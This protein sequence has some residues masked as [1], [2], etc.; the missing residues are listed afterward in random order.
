MKE[1]KIAFT[2]NWGQDSQVLYNKYKLI[3]PNRSG[4]WNYLKGV[5]TVDDADVVFM[6]DGVDVRDAPLLEKLKTKKLFA[7]RTEPPCVSKQPIRI[8]NILMDRVTTVDYTK[9]PIWYFA[10]WWE[11]SKAYSHEDFLDMPYGK[12]VGK[13]SCLLSNKNFTPGHQKRLKFVNRLADISP[14]LLTLYGRNNISINNG[15]L[16]HEDKYLAYKGSEYNL[17]FENCSIPN[18]FS[19]KMFDAILMWSM[20]IYFGATNISEYLPPDSFHSLSKNLDEGDIEKVKNICKYPPSKK[21]IKA[22]EESRHLILEKYS[23][24]ASL[25]YVL[26]NY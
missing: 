14:N 16:S 26:E 13:M 1:K 6:F 2:C 18:Y 5:P 17:C 24:W 7:V 19:D 4:Q 25:Q 11:M 3:A 21:N 15:A 8:P 9:Q 20:P 23:L 22:L 10:K 12:K